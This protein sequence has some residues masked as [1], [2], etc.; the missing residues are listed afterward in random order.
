MKCRLIHFR[1][2]AEYLTGIFFVASGIVVLSAYF[3]TE[4]EDD[5]FKQERTVL[6][7]VG[8]IHLTIFVQCLLS[9]AY[10][11]KILRNYV[12]PDDCIFNGLMEMLG[13]DKR[14]IPIDIEVGDDEKSRDYQEPDDISEKS[15]DH[16]VEDIK[17]EVTI[18]SQP[19]FGFTYKPGQNLPEEMSYNENFVAKLSSKVDLETFV[20]GEDEY[21]TIFDIAIEAVEEEKQRKT[22]GDTKPQRDP[23]EFIPLNPKFL[24]TYKTGEKGQHQNSESLLYSDNLVYHLPSDIDLEDIVLKDDKFI[25]DV[26]DLHIKES[27]N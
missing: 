15:D 10:T 20:I 7:V 17:R 1:L 16:E 4:A 14:V 2:F 21:P 9:C 24:F 3:R 6:L 23:N 22:Q 12:S 19:L 27:K 8:I 25:K 26:L 11:K 5:I 18:E 13:M